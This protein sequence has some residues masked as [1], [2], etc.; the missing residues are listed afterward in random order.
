MKR[1]LMGTLLALAFPGIAGALDFQGPEGALLGYDWLDGDYTVADVIGGHEYEGP[2]RDDLRPTAMTRATERVSEGFGVG[3]K[4]CNCLDIPGQDDPDCNDVFNAYASWCCRGVIWYTDRLVNAVQAY[5]GDSAGHVLELVAA[6]E[7]GHLVH[8][9]LV[10]FGG[11]PLPPPQTVAEPSFDLVATLLGDLLS[12]AAAGPFA[13]YYGYL[14]PV[15]DCGY[16]WSDGV[17]CADWYRRH[18]EEQLA[19]R[20]AAFAAALAEK[21]AA[22]LATLAAFEEWSAAFEAD[23]LNADYRRRL[24][25]IADCIAGSWFAGLASGLD[26]DEVG[27][28]IDMVIEV[29]AEMPHSTHPTDLDRVTATYHGVA[30]VHFG[31]EHIVNWCFDFIEIDTRSD[32]LVE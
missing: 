31:V 20:Q 7:I 15:T 2:C 28:V 21:R 6:H 17:G 29:G 10:H 4:S 18:W 16:L 14:H 23:Q 30:G 13:G 1:L 26:E 27:D 8:F 12:F 9:E 22:M 24:E 19:A 32:D 25:Q 11:S 5:Y 3:V